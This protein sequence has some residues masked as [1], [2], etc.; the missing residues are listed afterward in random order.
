MTAD[1]YSR[2]RVDAVL[3]EIAAPPSYRIF[4]TLH[5]ATPLGAAPSNSRFCSIEAGFAILY[6]APDFATA[7]VEVVVRDRFTRTKGRDIAV[8]EVMLRSQALVSSKRRTTL[9][10]IDLRKD[11]CTRLGAPTDSVNARNHAAGR[12]LGQDIYDNHRAVDGFLFSSRLTG[13]DVYAVFDRAL[14]KLT[15]SKPQPLAQ[16]AELPDVL[17][18]HDMRLVVRN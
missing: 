15:A 5:K 3:T 17:L 1:S 13:E 18:R 16:H 10:L 8:N 12:A 11:G 2:K 14:S 7:F 9:A 6:A 4:P